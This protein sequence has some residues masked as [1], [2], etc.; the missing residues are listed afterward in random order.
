MFET[1]LILEGCVGPLPAVLLLSVRLL[2][3]CSLAV[4]VNFQEVDLNFSL[5]IL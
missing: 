1:D 2:L 5:L 4:T 3:S